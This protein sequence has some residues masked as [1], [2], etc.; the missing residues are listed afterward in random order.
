[1]QPKQKHLFQKTKAFIFFQ[2]DISDVGKHECM[3]KNDAIHKNQ[4]NPFKYYIQPKFTKSQFPNITHQTQ[5]TTKKY[6]LKWEFVLANENYS[7]TPI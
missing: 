5:N 2:A 6:A 4:I 7:N 3:S 1:M